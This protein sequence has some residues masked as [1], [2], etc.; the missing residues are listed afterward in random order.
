VGP[1]ARIAIVG[2]SLAGL[3]A[4]TTLRR[5]GYT[6]GLTVFGQE[7]A[8]PY[9]RPPLS[10]QLLAGTWSRQSIDL[11]LDAGLDVDWRLGHAATSFDA[12]QLL[13]G[14]DHGR[15][16]SFDG[17]VIACGARPRTLPG[18]ALTGVHHLRTAEDSL[19]LRADLRRGPRRVVIVGAGFIGLEVA[20]TC[21]QLGLEVTVVEL[22]DVPLGP[23]LGEQVGTR[24]AELHRDRGV[25]FHFG[26]QVGGFRGRTRVEGVVLTDHTVLAA[27]VVLIAIGVRPNTGWLAGSGLTLDGGVVC[28]PTCLAAAGVVAA[29]DVA[30]WPNTR[31][32]EFRR[33]EHWDNAVRQAEHAARRLLGVTT[34]AYAPVPWVWSDQYDR[35][36]QVAGSTGA[37]DEVRVVWDD[38][39]AGRLLAL[40]RRGAALAGVFGINAARHVT[41]FRGLMARETT[42]W[43]DALELTG[44]LGRVEARRG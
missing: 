6:G 19:A 25:E 41:R 30:R 34:E 4:A 38:R 12:G 32:D 36:I 1:D 21:R 31:F 20:A 16:E 29:G 43:D 28:D 11:E 24:L 23:L 33:V 27:D 7:R 35:K 40:Y 8:R 10:K 9:D 2:A 39:D 5:E 15:H 17:V 37:S 14:F 18:S 42:A 26:A 3:T 44:S 13:L 22:L